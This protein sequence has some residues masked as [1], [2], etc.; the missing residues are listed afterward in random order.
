MLKR[1]L[2]YSL[3]LIVWML[4]LL[5]QNV[6]QA[7]VA[8]LDFELN[9][10]TL[11][12]TTPAEQQRTA[13]IRSM[14]ETALQQQGESLVS[15]ASTTQQQANHGFGYLYDHPEQVATLGQAAKADYVLVGRLHKPSFLFA[16]LLVKVVEVKTGTLLAEFK[17][18]SKGESLSTTQ[19]SIEVLAKDIHERLA[20]NAPIPT[21]TNNFSAPVYRQVTNKPFDDV[22]ADV[23]NA[24]S[25]HNFRLTEQAKVGEAIASREK[26]A[27][28]KVVILHFCNLTYAQTLIQTNPEA[29]LHMPCRLVIREQ[30]GKVIIET[31]LL[32]DKDNLQSMAAQINPILQAIVNSGAT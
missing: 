17:Q 22:L 7:A 3:P 28:P 15:I 24:I 10:L 13:A 12:T 30:H 27:F 25:Q 23:L 31:L 32:E 16:Y 2:K 18:E 19:K 26:I 6:V 1:R 9:D 21:T 8:V 14:L 4:S 20:T 5:W 29:I 11:V